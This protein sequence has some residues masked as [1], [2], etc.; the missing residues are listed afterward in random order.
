MNKGFTIPM[1]EELKWGDE[2]E[3]NVFYV[4]V[5]T[6]TIKLFADDGK[7]V[8]MANEIYAEEYAS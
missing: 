4:D 3:Y 6:N 7:L 8:E 1:T 5:R 2:V